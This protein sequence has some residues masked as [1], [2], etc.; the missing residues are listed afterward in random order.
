MIETKQE[1]VLVQGKNTSFG[2]RFKLFLGL[3]SLHLPGGLCAFQRQLLL[4]HA[5][6][7]ISAMLGTFECLH[8]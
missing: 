8:A 5:C 2:V 7:Q 3:C 6:I 4:F 1:V